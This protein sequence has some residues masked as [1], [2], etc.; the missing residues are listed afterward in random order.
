MAVRSMSPHGADPRAKNGCDVCV[1]TSYSADAEPRAPRHAATIARI[2]PAVRVTFVECLPF[3]ESPRPV[4]AIDELPNIQRLVC[5]FATRRSGLHRLLL[6]RSLGAVKR[7]RY[8]AIRRLDPGLLHS[9]AT[10]LAR[11][12]G[13]IKARAYVGHNIDTLLPVIQAAETRNSVAVFDCMEYYSDMGDGQTPSE[14]RLV[15]EIE[16]NGLGRCRLVLTSSDLLSDALV[17]AYG[18][19]RPLALYNAPPLEAHRSQHVNGTQGFR[20]YWRNSVLGFG[21]RGLEDALAALVLLPGDITL[22]VQGRLPPDGG[23]MLRTRISQLGLDSRVVIHPPYLHPHAVR[24]A[25]AHSVGLCLERPGNRNHEVTVSNKIFDYLMAGLPVVAS[26]LPALRS[27]IDRSDGGVVYQPG[28]A[29]E[30]ARKIRALYDD[31][32]T[33]RR[34]STNAR[35]FA[36][37]TGNLEHEMKKLSEALPSV[38]NCLAG[39]NA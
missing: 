13:E 27:I 36:V 8:M 12:L 21:Q 10:R 34:L 38:M 18:I 26:D 29:Q 32:V 11:M 37:Q 25:S 16:A 2:N 14:R 3:G 17:S 24:E 4:P 39:R 6:E 23:A 33:F 15:R 9:R 1:C 19:E 31:P 20:L 5:H 7:I 22:H 28:S 30:L 35:A